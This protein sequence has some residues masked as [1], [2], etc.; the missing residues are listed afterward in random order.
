MQN[1][2][3]PYLLSNHEKEDTIVA[4]PESGERGV[5]VPPYKPDIRARSLSKRMLP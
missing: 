1:L 3:Y 5:V 2:G 4:D